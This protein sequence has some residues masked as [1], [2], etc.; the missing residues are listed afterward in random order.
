MIF[1]ALPCVFILCY[2]IQYYEDKIR[3]SALQSSPGKNKV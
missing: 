2:F 1:I 3:K